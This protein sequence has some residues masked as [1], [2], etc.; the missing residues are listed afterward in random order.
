MSAST[1]SPAEI[2]DYILRRLPEARRAKLEELYF[3]DDSLLDRVEQAEDELVS[4]YVLGRLSPTDRK[5]FEDSLLE[6]P[7][8]RERIETTTQMRL[9]IGRHRAF[10]KSRTA[11]GRLLTG[12]AG[13]VAAISLLLVLFVA[14]LASALR[15]KSDLERATRALPAGPGAPNAVL[16]AVV[17]PLPG[18]AEA[19]R[20][21]RSGTAPLVLVLSRSH[22]P[23][24]GR[25]F[26]ISLR[27]ERGTAWESGL[28]PSEAARGGDLAVRLPEGVPGPGRY[29]V[30][31][32][33]DG[34]T[35]GPR[36]LASID[37]ALPE[38]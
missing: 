31:L 6:T 33:S 3:R 18:G 27:S 35:A 23:P 2:R 10:R 14:A 7:Y 13:F 29:D 38:G 16:E 32:A 4:D 28:L 17:L 30:V 24:A 15:L 19:G 8:Y 34:E 22:L 9:Q 25:P 20:V 21:V 11:D 36:V 5:T 26:R 37:F 1:P 12:R